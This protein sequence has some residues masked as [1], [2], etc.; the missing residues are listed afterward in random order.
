[1]ILV[2]LNSKGQALVEYILI[3]PIFLILVFI[4]IDFGMIFSRKN[5]LESISSDIVSLYENGTDMNNIEAEYNDIEVTFTNEEDYLKITIED[6][7]NLITPGLGIVLDDPF[8]I[9]VERVIPY[10]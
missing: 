4:T 9:T 8:I 5:Q 3:L 1:M 10:V 6:K 7:I 2:R